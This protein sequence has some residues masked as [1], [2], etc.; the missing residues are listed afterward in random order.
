MVCAPFRERVGFLSE[1]GQFPFGKPLTGVARPRMFC[2]TPVPLA[3]AIQTF[4]FRL[5]NVMLVAPLLEFSL[6]VLVFALRFAVLVLLFGVVCS[7][8]L[9]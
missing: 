8:S 5:V 6:S 1:A 7:V 3:S 2:I 9:V 4:L